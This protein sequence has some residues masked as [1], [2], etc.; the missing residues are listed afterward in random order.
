MIERL[1]A[2]WP[3]IRRVGIGTFFALVLWLIVDR[4]R[5]IEWASVW[6]SLRAYPPGVL[7]AAAALAAA[8]HAIYCSYDLIGRHLTGHRLTTLQVLRVGF[9]SYAFNLNLGSLVGGV[10]LRYRLYARLGLDIGLVTRILGLSL[11]TNWLGYLA[12]G[13]A[14][15]LWRPLALPPDWEIGS[16]GLRVL[17]AAMLAVAVTW[18]ALCGFAR[19]RTWQLRGH[20]VELPS[21]RIALLQLLLSMLNWALIASVVWVLL[22]QRIDPA[23]VLAVLL[24]AAVAGVIAHVPAGLG[25]L[26][27]VFLALLSHRAGHAELLAALLCYRALYYL[28]PLCLAAPL[29][30]WLEARAKAAGTADPQREREASMSNA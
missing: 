21:G 4:A 18:L 15:F 25:V 30:F 8:S 6:Q 20:A 28:A 19:Q 14:V 7:L 11:I 3:L 24:I 1:R 26:E 29:Y 2:H 17:G 13:G 9:V 10:A 27:G 22:Q 5:A 16:T 12:L 23:T